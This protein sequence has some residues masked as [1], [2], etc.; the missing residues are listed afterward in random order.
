MELSKLKMIIRREEGYKK[1]IAELENKIIELTSSELSSR[2]I[3]CL[4]LIC[5]FYK[6]IAAHLSNIATSVVMPVDFM[7]FFDEP[8]K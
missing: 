8:G 1:R 6:R 7:D 3:V 2:D 5:R 4:V